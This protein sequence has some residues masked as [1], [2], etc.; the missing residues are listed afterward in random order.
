MRFELIS[1]IGR[2]KALQSQWM[3]L[4]S[5]TAANDFFLLPQWVTAWWSAFSND[6]SLFVVAAWK[7]ERLCGLFPLIKMRK[8]P[9]RV[10]SFAGLPRAGRMDFILVDDDRREI[11]SE[12]VEWIFNRNDWDL[13]SLR[14]F[15]PFSQNPSELE[16]V[17]GA[18]GKYRT[19]TKEDVSYFIPMS[20]YEDF[21]QYFSHTRSRKTRKAFRRRKRK[22]IKEHRAQW[23]ITKRLNDTLI[24][25]MAD[26]DKNRSLRG[27]DERSFFSETQNMVFLKALAH[28]LAHEDMIRAVCLYV[29][30][31][32]CAFDLLFLYVGNTL[33]Y[34][35]AFDRSLNHFG[36]GNL[37][38]LESLQFA[39]VNKMKTYDFL[40]GDDRYKS[41]WAQDYHQNWRLQVYRKG[42]RSL[43][44]Y[45]Y[46]RTI[47]PLRRRMRRFSAIQNL[48][49]R[50]L[51][52]RLD[53]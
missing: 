12:F 21:D 9:F 15:G 6:K 23:T 19:F 38:L 3:A 24:D 44:L 18:I 4:L 30:G 34:Q 20:N 10:I 5:Q 40:S 42:P 32:L 13:L 43:V 36:A 48:L 14:A 37:T 7:K 47:K 26:L 50:K 1:N 53:I 41:K 22:L 46:H 11:L 2:L 49:P 8:G 45:F 35:T 52:S 33:S 28:E 29:D 27:E 25:E 17:L 39:F 16:R 51:R 31:R